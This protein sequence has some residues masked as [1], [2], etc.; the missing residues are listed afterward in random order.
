M[1]QKQIRVALHHK[2]IIEAVLMLSL[3]ASFV[4]AHSL[5]EP[6]KI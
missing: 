6:V 5:L 3:Y 4:G 1:L 2:E